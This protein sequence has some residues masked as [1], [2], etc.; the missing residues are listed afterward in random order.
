MANNLQLR[1]IT[2]EG[3]RLDEP[4]DMVI[5]RCNTGDMGILPKHTP[6]SAV[7]D[8]GVL[9][10]MN[11][12][13]ERRIAVMG[14][15]VQIKD[16]IVSVLTNEAQWPEEVDRA[17]AEADI[18]IFTLRV[19]EED[20]DLELLKHQAKLRRTFVRLEVSSYPLLSPGQKSGDS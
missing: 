5:M 2:R 18:D 3:V 17:R 14:G 9:R 19:Q 1:I 20:D 10:F 11:E 16:D 7:L 6:C 13:N 8:Y 15:V 12:G 4:C